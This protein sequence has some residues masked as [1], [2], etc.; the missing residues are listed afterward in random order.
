MNTR[1]VKRKKE[2]DVLKVYITVSLI[3]S[4]GIFFLLIRFA[5]LF[6]NNDAVFVDRVLLQ[7]NKDYHITADRD[8]ISLLHIQGAATIKHTFMEL[9]E[10][11]NRE[12]GCIEDYQIDKQDNN[13]I[14]TLFVS[15][16]NGRVF[17]IS[18]KKEFSAEKDV[19]N[20]IP[21]LKEDLQ[22]KPM[23]C[24]IIDDA[25]YDDSLIY[26]YMDLPIKMG[27][28]VLPFL[29]DSRKIAGLIH[30][31][32]K[33]VLLHMPMEPE[34][35]EESDIKLTQ[36]EI[37]T[38]MRKSK[39]LKAMDKMLESIQYAA[40][41]NNHQGSRATSDK[42]LMHT[43]LDEIKRRNMYFID[44]LTGSKSVTMDLAGE[45]NVKIGIRD[46]F[47]DNEDDYDSIKNRMEELIRI[48]LI[49]GKAIGIGHAGR[50][51]TYQVI[52]DYIPVIKKKGIRIVYPSDIV[53]RIDYLST[54][55]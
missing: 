54:R 42:R 46:V 8:E 35:Y 31:N 33:E 41:I 15:K 21:I 29:K 24:I 50:E 52:K 12:N 19:Q 43:V 28:A 20:E 6:R 7:L 10:L 36:D 18:I 32:G 13:L 16:N 27:I 30:E 11:I 14:L 4:L 40:G 55:R 1:Q 47:L 45:M 34:D 23:I 5:P 3:L 49:N 51:N 2:R 9:K 44:S 53:H 22:G 26:S 17:K 39:I 37:L 38:S 48:S 25:G